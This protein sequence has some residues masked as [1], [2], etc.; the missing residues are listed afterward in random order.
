MKHNLARRKSLRQSCRKASE[1]PQFDSFGVQPF[2]TLP[3]APWTG[4]VGQFH[5]WLELEEERKLERARLAL[6]FNSTSSSSSSSS[7]PSL[8]SVVQPS[9]FNSTSTSFYLAPVNR[10]PVRHHVHA[11]LPWNRR[12]SIATRGRQ[13]DNPKRARRAGTLGGTPLLALVTHPASPPTT[14]HSS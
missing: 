10:A 12:G 7:L 6:C 9:I 13:V 2:S 8:N 3:T 11:R 4:L 1:V 14:N 5:L